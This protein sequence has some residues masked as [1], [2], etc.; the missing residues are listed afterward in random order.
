MKKI[1][2]LL[3]ILL[4]T[5][6]FIP[7]VNAFSVTGTSSATV[8]SSVA[9]T[10][11]ASGLTGRFSIASSNPSVLSGGTSDWLENNRK[12]YYFTALK[13]G[14]ASVVVNAVNVSDANGN[15]F[16]GSRTF[17]VT[18]KS[19]QSSGGN[20][21]PVD[22][23]KTYSSNN[24][25]KSLS[26]EGYTLDPVFD[27]NTL[28]YNVTLDVDTTLIKVSAAQEDDT[29]SIT[30]IGDV[31][32]NDGENTITITVTAE[33]GNQKTYTIHATVK[34]LD[35]IKVTV[36]GKTYTIVRKKIEGKEVPTGFVE[37]Q[38][39]I[40]DQ[41]IYAYYSELLNITLVN[42]KDEKGNIKLF[43]YKDDNYTLFNQVESKSL[44]LVIYEKIPGV[45]FDF[46]KA[47]ITIKDEKV[48][49]LKIRDDDNFYLVYAKDLETGKEG[50]YLYDKE[51]GTYQRYFS[52]L[53]HMKNTEEKILLGIIA[54]LGSILGLIILVKLFKP[55][56]RKKKVD[57]N[58]DD[59]FEID[60]VN[61]S[62]EPVITKVEKDEY[63]V[64]K[65]TKKQKVKEIEEAKESLERSKKRI[66]RV[67]LDED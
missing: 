45:P 28:E 35:P 3:L 19:K 63:K 37:K 21:K 16:T 39:T 9:I 31:Q 4:M 55:K 59:T 12:T 40:K 38:I 64:P 10:V 14:T 58:E 65:K 43:M 24:F 7:K 44:N 56:N 25:L 1:K 57:F 32:V 27:K 50:Y 47:T 62:D 20:K 8:G 29:A 53:T 48:E 41:N 6:V 13:E 5:F 22:V 18:V 61:F 34:E 15:E 66:K 11:E 49:A 17:Y 42:L 60:K 67:S 52:A 26:V 46:E 36:K 54:V 30:G 23:N 2:Y 33:N 51:E